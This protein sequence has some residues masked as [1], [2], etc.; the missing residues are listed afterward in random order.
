MAVHMAL[1]STQ[2]CRLA[3]SSAGTAAGPPGP[4]TG[5]GSPR[6]LPSP[7]TAASHGVLV[8]PQ[9]AAGSG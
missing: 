1:N 7:S 3:P 5:L 6:T 9:E 4:E 2:Q 8:R